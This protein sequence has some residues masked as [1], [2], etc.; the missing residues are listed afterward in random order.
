MFAENVACGSRR[1]ETLCIELCESPQNRYTMWSWK[2]LFLLVF[3]IA[4]NDG[5]DPRCGDIDRCFNHSGTDLDRC[6]NDADRRIGHGND[7]TA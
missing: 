6:G 2:Q 5:L 3:I 4:A 7:C 1:Y